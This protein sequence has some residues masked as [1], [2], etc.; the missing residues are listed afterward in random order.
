MRSLGKAMTAHP[1]R[2]HLIG[3][4]IADWQG[5]E[6][7]V[8]EI[9]TLRGMALKSLKVREVPPNI[10]QPINLL[11]MPKY[12][13]LLFAIALLSSGCITHGNDAVSPNSSPSSDTLNTQLES[14]EDQAIQEGMA[15]SGADATDAAAI[16]TADQRGAAVIRSTDNEQTILGNV[17]LTETSDG[18][19][20]QANFVGVPSGEH[21]FHIHA[22]GS[23]ADSGQAAG[24]HY[25]PDSVRHG[26]LPEDGVGEAHAGDM[27]NVAIAEDGTGA[28]MAT[29]PQLT[30]AEGPYSVAE[31]AIILHADPDD[32]SQP[33]GNAGGRIGC[34]IIEVN[35]S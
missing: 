15:G 1:H 6:T 27:G 21:G 35:Q 8:K 5:N 22:E 2:M 32:F 17:E 23:C 19:V 31:R 34:G 4:A 13:Y 24:G 18:L 10:D 29:M 16:A 28:Y 14:L 20:I 33:T 26:Y 11:P 7:S 30:L 9:A 25:N 12:L 3:N